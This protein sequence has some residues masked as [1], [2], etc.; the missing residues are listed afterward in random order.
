M[1]S[2]GAKAPDFELAD[3]D[4]KPVRL[5]SLLSSGPVLLAFF[6]VTCPVCQYTFPFLERVGGSGRVLGI[7][8]DSPEDTH[9]FRR[10]FAVTVP[11]VFDLAP[12]YRIS[13]AYGITNVPSL[14]LIE[15]DGTVALAGS[16]F[17]R[18]D[19]ETVAARLGAPI[20][21]EHEQVPEFRPG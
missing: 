10:T 5:T 15:P 20:F 17:S 13:N 6:K 18:L 16:G 4:G 14:F 19:L 12:A 21:R 8:Q 3:V 11:T 2:A 9:E 1:V 7:S